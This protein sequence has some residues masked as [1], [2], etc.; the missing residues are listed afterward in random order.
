MRGV[1]PL[2]VSVD[3]IK[4]PRFSGVLDAYR[5][6]WRETFDPS[7]SFT[8]NALARTKNFY[9]VSYSFTERH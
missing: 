8:W 6:T 3:S 5:Q 7:R 4:K 2:T 9:K 1:M